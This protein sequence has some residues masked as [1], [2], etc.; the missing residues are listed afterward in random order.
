MGFFGSDKRHLPGPFLKRAAYALFGEVHV[1]G[2]LRAYHVMARL[3]ELGLTRRR[4]LKVLDVGCG[5]GDL[6][7]WL[8]RSFPTWEVRGMEIDPERL[9]IA[10]GV[11]EKLGL[12]NLSF[13]YGNI[14][15][16]GFEESA[17]LIVSCD[18]LE[19]IEDD[20]TALA[21]LFA[22]LGPG[23]ILLL[24]FP[25]VPQRKH[26]WLVARREKRL[27]I[28]LEDSGHV[29]QGYEAGE[30]RRRLKGI[31]FSAVECRPTYG[32]W[33]TLCFD[34]FF[35]LGDNDPNPAVFLLAFPW[36]MAL[37]W[38]DVWFPC[39]TGSGLLVTGERPG[40]GVR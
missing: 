15:E 3:R 27:G 39:E 28:T 8:A 38:M 9:A 5:R 6:S 1:P 7:V 26:L 23:G 24:T 36:L 11:A 30:T 34:V 13:A 25:S 33:G 32:F 40:R 21:N 31:G 29:R 2:R 22:S 37:A 14:L 16:G 20:Q 10:K 12:P 17:D 18:V 4:G 19:H 35:V